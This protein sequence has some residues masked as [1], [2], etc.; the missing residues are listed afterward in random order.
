MEYFTINDEHYLAIANHAIGNILNLTDKLKV[1]LGINS[2]TQKKS[3]VIT[4][5]T[6]K[7]FH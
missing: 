2:N 3:T 5:I 7:Y 6:N 4:G 1:D